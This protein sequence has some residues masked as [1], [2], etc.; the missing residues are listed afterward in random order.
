MPS[1]NELAALEAEESGGV[2]IVKIGKKRLA[3]VRSI[4]SQS[5]RNNRKPFGVAKLLEQEAG[6]PRDK[7]DWKRVARTEMT[8]ARGASSFAMLAKTLGP[9]GRIYRD[10][11]DC[12]HDCEKLFGSPGA[13]RV[14]RVKH[15]KKAI[16]GAVHP[17]C[18]CSG[19]KSDSVPD[20]AKG[21]RTMPFGWVRRQMR[22]VS[23]VAEISTGQLWVPL[24]SIS[25]RSVVRAI[26][27]H[28]PLVVV[29]E[30]EGFTVARHGH[31]KPLGSSYK[32]LAPSQVM[33]AR[34]YDR[35]P[36]ADL[37]HIEEMRARQARTWD[38]YMERILSILPVIVAMPDFWPGG[39]GFKYLT[40]FMGFK[41]MSDWY[42]LIP[43]EPSDVL[44]VEPGS[45]GVRAAVKTWNQQLLA[46]NALRKG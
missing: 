24:D 4:I 14:W 9:N 44:S 33:G 27:I 22:G 12:C 16:Q 21:D 40:E 34:Y 6:G 11:S 36:F 39:Q 2:Q 17:N 15:V 10:T 35:K 37:P 3:T 38:D 5:L 46:I 8:N 28:T 19:W 1:A 18:R 30:Q 7:R 31:G 13:P 23:Y 20:L 32:L 29:G 45:R 42:V 26:L 25:G 41:Q 43:G